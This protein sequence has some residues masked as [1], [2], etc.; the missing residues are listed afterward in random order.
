MSDGYAT[1]PSVLEGC[2]TGEVEPV[3]LRPREG[4]AR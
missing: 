1:V 4:A 3:A 2:R